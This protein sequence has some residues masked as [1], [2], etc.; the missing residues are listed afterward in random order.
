MGHFRYRGSDKF[1]SG[2]VRGDFLQ[3]IG[4]VTEGGLGRKKKVC[5]QYVSYILK[6]AVSRG[7]CHPEASRNSVMNPI[8]RRR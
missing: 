4:K 7:V 2:L 8:C 5:M 1:K 6:Q 3:D